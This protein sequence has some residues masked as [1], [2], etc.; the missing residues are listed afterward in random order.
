M[1]EGLQSVAHPDAFEAL[2]F[3]RGSFTS[4][5]S[6]AFA[7]GRG[8]IE[9]GGGLLYELNPSSG[10]IGWSA[11]AAGGSFVTAPIVINGNVFEGTSGG[12][13]YEFNGASGALLDTVNVGS[14]ISGPDEQN[15]SQPLTGLG[16]GEGLLVVPAGDTVNVYSV[17]TPTPEPSS[18][19]LLLAGGLC[20]PGYGSRRRLAKTA[21]PT[22]FDQQDA[23]A[24][25]SLS[26]RSSVYVHEG[27][28]D[29]AA[30]GD[31]GAISLL[32]IPDS[33]T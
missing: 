28:V 30:G 7:N 9:A 29:L 32:L 17:T 5:T 4:P 14:G 3:R 10:A 21:K 33:R 20:R 11:L 1:C 26:S 12:L 8:Y 2:A 13:L 16:A 22:A 24:I 6:P 23:P 18:I 19:A 15:V 31:I 25:L 27:Q